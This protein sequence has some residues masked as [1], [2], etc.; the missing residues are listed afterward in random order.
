MHQG[1]CVWNG[2]SG[3]Q[4]TYYIFAAPPNFSASQDGNYIYSKLVEN[5]WQPIY[6]GEGDLRDR[7]ENHHR[8][9]CL[10][11]KGATHVHA[12]L[13]ASQQ[14]RRRE[15]SDLLAGYIQAYVP[16]GCNIRPGG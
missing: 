4:Y 8:A 16:A 6:I 12:H 10:A 2:A 1:T 13:N 14:D 9:E 15:E 7:T 11:K 5:Y 3:A